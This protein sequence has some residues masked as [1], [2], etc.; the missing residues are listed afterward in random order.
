MAAKEC[1]MKLLDLRKDQPLSLLDAAEFLGKITGQKPRIST[2]C[3]PYLGLNIC[4]L[5]RRFPA[6]R[7]AISYGRFH[8]FAFS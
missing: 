3:C 5:A 2:L 6:N 4:W 7:W 8:S 1:P